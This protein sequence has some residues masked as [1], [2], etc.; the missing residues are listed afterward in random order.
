MKTVEGCLLAASRRVMPNH[1]DIVFFQDYTK[2][3]QAN[4]DENVWK[5]LCILPYDGFQH[6]NTRQDLPK[7]CIRGKGSGQS[8]T[9]VMAETT[10]AVDSRTD[11][12]APMEQQY[13]L[14]IVDRYSE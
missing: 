7:I 14:L 4:K 13:Y 8:R 2:L 9:T 3:M 1:F 12:P 6:R 10:L 11:F 5:K